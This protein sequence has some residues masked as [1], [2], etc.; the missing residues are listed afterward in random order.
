M[1]AVIIINV[2]NHSDPSGLKTVQARFG[3]ASISGEVDGCDDCKKALET[4]AY[5][6]PAF[7]YDQISACGDMGYNMCWLHL[8]RPHG[9]HTLKGRGKYTMPLVSK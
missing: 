2:H 3:N 5:L 1:A 4:D 6:A 8:S 7:F 9:K